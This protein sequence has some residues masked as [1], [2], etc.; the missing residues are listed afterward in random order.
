[1]LSVN[2]IRQWKTQGYVIANNIINSTILQ[3]SV[4]FMNRKYYNKET[5][6]KGFGSIN[7]ELEF[8][9][10]KVIDWLTLDPNLILAVKQLLK[11]PD[12]LLTQSDAWGKYGSLDRSAQK[13]NDQ[14]MHMDYGNNS[15]LHPDVWSEPEAVS[16][17]IYLS[18]TK[19]TGG[20][21]AVVPRKGLND[22][23]YQFPYINMP[24][25][26][27]IE[28]F[29]DRQHAE[30]YIQQINPKMATFRQKLYQRE[31]KLKPKIGDILFY[32]LDTW[33]RGTPVNK[34]H[35]RNVMNL[36]WKK[37]NC[38]WIH[39]WNSAWTKKMYYG[40][41]EK[42]FIQMTPTQRE[43]LGIPRPGDS[44]WNY[45]KIRNLKSRY[46]QIDIKP[47]LSKL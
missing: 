28:F 25:Q 29:N 39:V 36:V 23:L 15:F 5:A 44:Y 40:T 24:G 43:V 22:P 20:G 33:H 1:M 18:D 16:V 31:L 34:G 2:D 7:G 37:K 13:N 14:R 12:I 9:S 10:G 11:T 19:V 27:N 4:D 45:L 46:P 41:I 21:T 35:I 17:I 30:E 26:A 8:P 32:R 47:Y 38:H 42:L 3:Q 6:P